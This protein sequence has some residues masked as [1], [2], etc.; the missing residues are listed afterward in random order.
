MKTITSITGA[1]NNDPTVHRILSIG[2]THA[3]CVVALTN[4]KNALVQK[5]CELESI[6]PKKI[7][8]SDGSVLV[9]HCPNDLIPTQPY[10][11]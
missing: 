4:E 9:W 2:G 8:M 6:A 3:D 11:L 7:E 1:M 10:A 5:L